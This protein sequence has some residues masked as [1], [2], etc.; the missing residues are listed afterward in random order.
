MYDAIR[1]GEEV[2]RDPR[3][4]LARVHGMLFAS[5]EEGDVEAFGWMPSHCK[6]G[7]LQH[8]LAKKSDG[9][10]LTSKDV[11]MNDLAD[12]L[13]KEGVEQHRV[14]PGVVRAWKEKEKQVEVRARWIGIVTYEANSSKAYPFRDSEAARWK[15]DAAQRRRREAEQGKDGRR[16]RSARSLKKEIGP[17]N[18]GHRLV[19]AATGH[20]WICE[21]CKSGHW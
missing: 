9:S 15:A 1:K 7:D 11:E 3:N 14:P 6:K 5:L 20:G 18:G 10:A 2:S 19:K 16:R 13:A 4:A 8:E 21:I 17:G 12:Y